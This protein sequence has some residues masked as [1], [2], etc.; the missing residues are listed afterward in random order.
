MGS[1]IESKKGFSYVAYDEDLDISI[2]DV[3]APSFLQEFQDA[4]ALSTG[5]G[6]LF[7]D[8][9]MKAI[10]KP[11]NFKD[12]CS[13]YFRKCK[14][15]CEKCS[16]SD[17]N[18]ISTISSTNKPFI[19]YCENGLIDFGAPVILN[20]KTIGTLIAGQV[21]VEK[22]D[23]DHFREYAKEIGADEHGFM[24]A[25]S[26]VPV[27]SEKQVQ[28]MLRLLSLVGEQL[29][30][31]GYQR[32]LLIKASEKLHDNIVNIM[33]N[34][35]EV[36]ASASEFSSNQW[37]LN[38]KIQSVFHITEKINSVMDLIQSIASKTKLLGVNASIEAARAGTFG[39][40]FGIVATE[41]QKLSDTS[42]N[43]VNEIKLFTS[44]IKGTI[45][46]T[47]EIFENTATISNEQ[48]KAMK[49]IVELIEEITV[50]SKELTMLA[51]HDLF[52]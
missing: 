38:D 13:N 14:K 31:M 7:F 1:S 11:S 26:K 40:G 51:N 46:N 29:S 41:I 19:S 18:L 44:Q 36:S 33:A 37:E 4:F 27:M 16:K 5:A 22:P 43:T 24:N 30:E 49:A 6:A 45:D 21:L 2:E 23:E 12:I 17:T 15:S 42:N 3:I 9:N 10:T 47:L 8:K 20:G 48:E 50:L 52:N 39:L 34:T 28:A 32:L 25:L 35:E